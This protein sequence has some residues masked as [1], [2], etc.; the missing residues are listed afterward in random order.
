MPTQQVN[1]T[2]A[3]STD[4]QPQALLGLDPCGEVFTLNGRVFRGVFQGY[5][6]Q[7]L[8][9]YDQ[10]NK[11]GFFDAGV[12][13]TFLCD[14]DSLRHYGYDLVF[15]HERVPFITYAHEWSPQMFKDSA[16]FQLDLNKRLIAQGLVLKDC[17]SHANVLFNDTTPV[18]V[19]FLSIIPI[20]ELVN[21]DWLAP[22]SLQDISL[23]SAMFYE[24]FKRI[25]FPGMLFPL[26]L[27]HQGKRDYTQKRIFETFLNTAH[28]SIDEVEA[29]AH[30]S[31]RLKT[32]YKYYS[33][34]KI[35]ALRNNDWNR[36]LEIQQIEIEQLIVGRT[37]SAYSDYYDSKG[38]NFP[39]VPTP[40]WKAKQWAVYNALQKFKPKTVLDIGANTGWFS[41]LAATCGA[42][43]I[44]AEID[45]ACTDILYEQLRR[46]NYSVQPLVLDILD[47]TPDLP[48]HPSFAD[49]IHFS[50]SRFGNKA[51]LLRNAQSRLQCDLVV[52][53]ALIH[54]LCL[55]RGLHM[56]EAVR[57][58][59]DYSREVLLL[60]FVDITDPLIIGE[61]DFFKA[62]CYSP[63]Q[64]GW[65]T[66]EECKLE[67]TN[68][69][70]N[71]ES[72]PLT[73]TRTL[74]VCNMQYPIE[75]KEDQMLN[76]VEHI[77]W[78]D[79][80]IATII[81]RDFMP[82]ETTFISPDSYYQQLGFVVY[83]KDGVVV[84]H[85]H[86]PLQRHLVGTPETLLI[87]R[88]RAEVGL[89]AM[90]KSPLGTW[91][92]EEGDMIQLVAGG[93][94]FKC[95]EDTIFVEIKQGPYTGLVEKER[96]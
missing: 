66:I 27:M 80:H 78:S 63:D 84:R 17:G 46:G 61:P 96:F 72:I 14:D 93:H 69:F 82:L 94:C 33:D 58:L 83:P 92:L 43:V 28:D 45:S 39:F 37:S 77:T 41:V 71:I 42:K 35:E 16:L 91:I 13:K 48:A 53:L 12:V 68:Y 89:Y 24:V 22:V 95:L 26:Y 55:G 40:D 11:A 38:E 23:P 36:F 74:L 30:A 32:H 50:H 29:F 31:E 34:F 21:Q 47:V 62:H 60:E 54:H 19:D 67:L 44:A 56:T 86:L 1:C 10:C 70:T 59:T 75:Q 2:N 88:G 5:G 52:A 15:E 87:R 85:A 64:F 7:I 90:D 57:L 9:V 20:E 49:D 4:E 81:R 25:F 65:Y 8:K 3:L 18:Y 79:Q 73:A 51:P 76:P 6:Q